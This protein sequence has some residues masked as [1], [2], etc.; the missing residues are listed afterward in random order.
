MKKSLCAMHEKGIKLITLQLEFD[1]EHLSH[2]SCRI[3]T[4]H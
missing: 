2:K 1:K 3:Y 4:F